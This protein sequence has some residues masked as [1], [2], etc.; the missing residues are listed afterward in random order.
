M[1][2]FRI[3]PYTEKQ[4]TL[5]DDF[6]MRQSANGTFLQTR[7]FLSYHP[8]ERFVDCSF[9]IF[10]KEELI[11]VCPATEMNIDGKRWFRSHAGSTFGGVVLLA[12]EQRTGNVIA[13]LQSLQSTLTS[14]G[15]DVIEWKLTPALLSASPDCSLDYALYQ[16]GYS[17]EMEIACYL[18]LHSPY[19][20]LRAAY[21]YNKRYDLAKAEKQN[22]T[23][24]L[25][26]TRADLEEFHAL[27]C[28]NLQKFN[29]T[30]VHTADELW[31][32]S[33]SRLV[34]EIRFIGLRTEAGALVAGACLFAFAQTN[35][36]HT[37]YLATDTTIKKY[38]PSTLLYDTVSR[39]AQHEGYSSL[40]LGTCTHD[41]GRILN[42]GLMQ[43]K[44]G[45]GTS[46]YINTIYTKVL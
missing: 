15:F 46:H 36:L 4:A 12:K 42:S 23:P 26:S 45:Y 13:I 16:Q 34:N 44:E 39:Y 18:P 22:L 24:C 9:L 38:V 35:V 40:S 31:D 10:Q 20:T 17:Q 28:L 1:S 21:S 30:P 5:W 37:Q 19:E 8:V 14:L 32:F 27:L 3:I 43:N 2:E 7:R 41:R 29:A 33:S 11:A 6:V 25:L